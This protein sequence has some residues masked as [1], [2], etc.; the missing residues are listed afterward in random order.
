MLRTSSRI[1]QLIKYGVRME[2]AAGGG[3]IS[4]GIASSGSSGGGHSGRY[5]PSGVSPGG[6][7]AAISGANHDFANAYSANVVSNGYVFHG[8]F[9]QAIGKIYNGV[10]WGKFFAGFGVFAAGGATAIG[11]VVLT[12]ALLTGEH[13]LA[14]PTA[15]ASLLLTVHSVTLGGTIIATGGTIAKIGVHMMWDA[16]KSESSMPKNHNH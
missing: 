11:G 7:Y 6:G 5:F 2:V 12:G 4:S 16:L 14:V 9:Y 10:K 8:E 15:G 1:I 13:A 3:S